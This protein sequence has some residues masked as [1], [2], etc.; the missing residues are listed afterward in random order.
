M[1]ATDHRKRICA[2]EIC[3]AGNLG[4]G[5]F[6]GVDEVGVFSSRDRIRA[7]A[8]HSVFA[9][10]HDLHPRRY[11]VSDER[12][13]ADAEV[14]VE[15][16]AQL[17]SDALH[18]ALAL[19]DIFLLVWFWKSGHGSLATLHRGNRLLPLAEFFQIG[20][21]GA[22]DEGDH[23][24]IIQVSEHRDKVWNDVDGIKKIKNT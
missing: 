20:M 7:Y 6:A 11:V 23:H 17:E 10:K 1:A 2:G 24:A 21:N 13:H 3:G 22:S 4:D 16:V 8:Q 18:D 5:L 14:H 9:L 15:A 19:L 12:G